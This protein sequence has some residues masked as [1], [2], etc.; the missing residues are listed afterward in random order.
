VQHMSPQQFGKHVSSYS[1]TW[2]RIVKN[3]GF[4]AQ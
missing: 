2:A 3:N 1:Q 4:Q